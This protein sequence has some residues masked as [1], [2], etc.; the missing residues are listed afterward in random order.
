[1]ALFVALF[2]LV[3][4]MVIYC[5]LA[6][7]KIGGR[8]ATEELIAGLTFLLAIVMVFYSLL[9]LLEASP[10]YDSITAV[11]RWVIVVIVPVIGFMFLALGAQDSE[12]IRSLPPRPGAPRLCDGSSAVS[13]TGW[14]LLGALRPF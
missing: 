9:L 6:G 8:A 14:G 13:A 3:A 11:A 7:D 4:T 1:M 2:A 5:V 12:Y 10:G